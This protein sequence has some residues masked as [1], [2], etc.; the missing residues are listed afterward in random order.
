[1]LGACLVM[2]DH[3]VEIWPVSTIFLGTTLDKISIFLCT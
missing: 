1:M 3:P 2:R